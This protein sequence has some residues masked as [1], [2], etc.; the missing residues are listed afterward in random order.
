[1]LGSIPR[2]TPH[3]PLFGDIMSAFDWITKPKLMMSFLDYLFQYAE[4]GLLIFSMSLILYYRRSR[5]IAQIKKL[6]G[7]NCTC[8][9]C[10]GVTR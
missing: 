8:W 6:H 4:I 7:P 3:R 1:M 10:M 9:T 5:E 2:K